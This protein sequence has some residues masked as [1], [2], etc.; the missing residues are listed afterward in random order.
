MNDYHNH[1]LAGADDLD[2]AMSKLWAFYKKYFVG[3]YVISVLMA[4][5]VRGYH[6]Q[7]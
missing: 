1:P 4:T 5:P 2:S 6:F 7:V 3:M